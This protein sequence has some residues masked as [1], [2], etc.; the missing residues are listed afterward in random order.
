MKS[1]QEQI[2]NFVDPDRD[3]LK[4]D[5]EAP[6]SAVVATFHEPSELVLVA[7]EQLQDALLMYMSEDKISLMLEDV[8]QLR[9][10]KI[11][12]LGSHSIF[13]SLEY[14]SAMSRLY[15]IELGAPKTATLH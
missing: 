14:P 4:R 13:F 5:G 15:E 6:I 11:I 12:P 1:P 2:L 7:L 9:S 3:L 8:V 10:G